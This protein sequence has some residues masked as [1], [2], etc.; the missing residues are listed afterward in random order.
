VL[1]ISATMTYHIP[2]V[3][4][5]IIRVRARGDLA[6]VRVLV[7]GHPFNIDP[8]LWQRVGAD[9]YAINATSAVAEA[10]RLTAKE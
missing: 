7:G 10:R 1:A 2:N 5:L 8:N 6:G 9:G 4:D 3:R